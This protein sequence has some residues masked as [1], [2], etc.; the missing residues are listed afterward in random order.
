MAEF[1]SINEAIE[2]I[3]KGNFVVV[4]DDENRENEGDLII[5]A[6]K[7]TTEKINFMTKYGRGLVCMPVEG[8]R[9]EELNIHQW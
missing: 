5:A 9:L 7:V 1:N 3:R 2:E 6:E 8:E 4:L